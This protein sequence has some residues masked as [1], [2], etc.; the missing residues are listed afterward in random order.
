MSKPCSKCKGEMLLSILD[1]FHGEQGG[2][3]LSVHEMPSLICTQ[4]HKRFIHIEF[5]AQLMD[6]VMSPETYRDIPVAVKKGLFKK[7]YHCPG[8]DLELPESPTGHKTQELAAELGKAQ[9]FKLVVDMP[10]FRCGGCG[11]ESI[12]SVEETGKLAFKATDHAYRS[13]D[14]HPS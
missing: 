12:H 14:I 4:G 6:L 2:L 7:R 3:K 13:I 8:C 1:P 9:P 11:K 5:A 10:V